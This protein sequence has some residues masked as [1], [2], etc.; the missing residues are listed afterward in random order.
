MDKNIRSE[1]VCCLSQCIQRNS[2]F[3]KAFLKTR[4]KQVNGNDG[5]AYGINPHGTSFLERCLFLTKE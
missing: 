1:E 5:H 3:T 2:E 4:S